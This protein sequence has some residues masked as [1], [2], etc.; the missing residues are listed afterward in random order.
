MFKIGIAGCGRIASSFDDDPKRKYISTHIGAYKC[1][2]N[3]DVVAVCDVN[4]KSLEKCLKKWGISRGYL[5]LKEMLRKEKIDILSIC[6]P[7]DTHYAILKQAIEFPLKAIFCEKPLA[8]NLKDAEKMVRLCKQKKII[9]QVDHQRRF[10]PL[11]VNLRNF[12]KYKKL[13]DIQQVN[14]YYT[15]GIKNTGSH[16]FDILRFFF[17]EIDWIE[18][19]FSK[20]KSNNERDPNLDGIL[21]FKGGLFGTFQACN[22]KK[23][24]I[25]ELSCFLNEG[26]FILKNSGFSVDFYGVRDSLCFS[27]YKELYKNKTPFNIHYRRNFMVNAVKHLLGCIQKN[28]D[29]ISSGKDGLKALG[30]IEASI[31]SANNNGKKIYL[32]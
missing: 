6:T 9:L 21:K 16:M 20:N 1:V 11:H 32:D 8:D 10:D 17:G 19:M 4:K 25:F 27:G 24:L 26:K 28:K 2:G 23:Y 29:S 15:A 18:A 22:A 3:T 7:P 5:S 14:F 30:L 13:G 12:I 31:I